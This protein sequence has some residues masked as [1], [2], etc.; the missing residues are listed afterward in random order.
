MALF[1]FEKEVIKEHEAVRK[2]ANDLVWSSL[3]NPQSSGDILSMLGKYFKSISISSV[4]HFS[5][6]SLQLFVHWP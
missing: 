2:K 1:F 6:T 3:Q 4:S 5:Y